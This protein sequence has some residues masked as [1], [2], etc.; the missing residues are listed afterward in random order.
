MDDVFVAQILH[1]SSNI[2]HELDKNL[3]RE[4]LQK[5]RDINKHLHGGMDPIN[6]MY[7]CCV[8]VYEVV[9]GKTYKWFISEA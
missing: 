3:L 5:T 1:P 2:Q 8:R 7:S 6:L 4:G 9:T